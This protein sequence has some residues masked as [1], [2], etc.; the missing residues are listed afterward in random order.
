MQILPVGS[1]QISASGGRQT[2]GASASFTQ[3]PMQNWTQRLDSPTGQRF[4][5]VIAEK[6]GISQADLKSQLESGTTLQDI[7]KSKNLTFSDIR[8]AAQAQAGQVQFS[9]RH[10]AHGHH[11][12]GASAV[13]S[14]V[15]G[16][17]ADKLGMQ[18][19]DLKQQLDNG[20]SLGQLASDKGV[21]TGDLGRRGRAGASV[22]ARVRV[23]WLPGAREPGAGDA[24]QRDR[25][26]TDAP[27]PS[28]TGTSVF[29]D[30]V[31]SLVVVH[32]RHDEECEPAMRRA[33]DRF[34]EVEAVCSRF[35]PLSELSRLSA[36]VGVPVA[37]SPLILGA[38]GYAME[39]AS[40]TGGGFDPTVGRVMEQNGFNRNYRTGERVVNGTA[41]RS[42]SYR[43]VEVDRARGTV[44]LRRPLVLDL[45]ALAKG[46]AIDLAARE[47]LE[48]E[49]FAIDAGGDVYVHGADVN[50]RPWQVGVRDPRHI[51]RTSWML[52]AGSAAVCTS[53]DYERPGTTGAHH[54]VQPRSGLA[55]R[56]SVSATVVA[57][58]AMEADALA[59]AAFVVGPNAG[60]EFLESQG[61]EGMIVS[62]SLELHETRGWSNCCG[63]AAAA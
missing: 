47:L 37:V 46:L 57:P 23:E 55:V 15:L 25:L 28:C 58:S 45:G 24:G 14:A 40:A 54:L 63:L 62:G 10:H 35:D 36:T 34:A 7:L 29:M 50:G 13:D 56:S 21:S 9:A 60:I 2:T 61:V 26:M 18:P 4:L 11:G 43:D 38:I 20:A 17:I 52:S 19:S 22:V 1:S 8:K 59:T 51:G 6:T 42:A 31:V 41:Q 3:M 48:H 27:A 44:F 32:Q 30:T 5:Q 49:D 39:I 33:F 53:G 16:A 12:G